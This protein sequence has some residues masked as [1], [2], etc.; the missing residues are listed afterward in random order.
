MSDPQFVV[1]VEAGL[2]KNSYGADIRYSPPLARA[3]IDAYF[4]EVTAGRHPELFNPQPG[5]SLLKVT[6]TQFVAIHPHRLQP[7]ELTRVT[8]AELVRTF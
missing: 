6:D 1:I 7:D 5:T 4:A 3:E 8:L 2:R